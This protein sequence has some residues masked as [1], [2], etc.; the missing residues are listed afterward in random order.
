MCLFIRYIEKW[1][2]ILQEYSNRK[3]CKIFKVCL[4]IL[5][6]MEEHKIVR[7]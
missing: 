3:H 6:V 5:N 1:L 2:N 4:T 7:Y